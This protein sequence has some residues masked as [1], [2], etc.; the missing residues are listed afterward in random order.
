IKGFVSFENED[1]LKVNVK[2]VEK[3]EFKITDAT[4][5]F[6][7]KELEAGTY[8]VEV[9]LIGYKTKTQ[10]VEIGKNEIKRIEFKMEIS[11]SELDEVII[12]DQQTGLNNKTPYS[13]TPVKMDRIAY[14]SSPSGVMGVLRDVPGVYGAEFGQG[15][16]KPFIRGLGFSRVATI[17]QGNK[18]ENQQ[19]G[20]DHG[21]GVNDLG[22]KRIEII[23]GPA[24]VLYGSGALGGVI[25]IKDDQFYKDSENISG[26]VGTTYNSVSQG[27]RT[28][29]S[30]GKKFENGLYF[31]S[32]LA[33]ENHADYKSGYGEIIGNSRF[34]MKTF[35]FHLGLEKSDFNNRLSVTYN[36][37]NLGIISDDELQN[38]NAST[39]NDRDMQLP[40][41]EVEDLLLSYN[42]HTNHKN[43]ET[44]LH[45]SHHWNN[46]KEIENNYD[47]VD[48]GLRQHNT[49]YNANIGFSTKDLNHSLGIQGNRLQNKNHRNAKEILI[50]DAVFYENALYYMLDFDWNSYFIQAAIRYD[51][52]DVEADASDAFFVSNNFL[53]P[54][55]PEN[56]KLNSNFGGWTGSIGVSKDFNKIHKVKMNFSSGFRSPDLA[57]LYSFGQHPGTNRFEVGNANFNREQSLQLDMNYTLTTNRLRFDLSVF[58]SQIDNYIFF[59][60]TGETQAESDLQIW[61]Y[62]QVEAE[63]Y[64]SEAS[65]QYFALKNRQLKLNLGAALVRGNNLDFDEPL[66]FIPPDN[67]NFQANYSFGKQQQTSVFGQLRWVDEQDRPGFN[68]IATEGYQLVSLGIDHEFNFKSL[69]IE[70]ALK[71]DNLFN[72]NYVDHLS[73][74]RAFNIPSPGRNLNLNLRLH[75]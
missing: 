21:L 35:R 40:F 56:R 63:L 45:I 61:E 69:K 10:T 58:G 30:V 27:F 46:R 53:L 32:D 75:F 67:F 74:L 22:V 57:E 28:Y 23:K 59:S 54:G 9:S 72:E 71:I 43:F 64:G 60:D 15:I 16:V 7:F 18:L 25:L 34:N 5:S 13:F 47:E 14:K 42:Q 44:N 11:A 6:E 3:N 49:F 68:E 73:I 12:L 39:R 65:L 38:S 51:Y 1:N 26:S 31:G 19:W 4:N 29:A 66:T 36:Q 50:P 52:R 55:E 2:L 33:Y 17:Y 48:L 20:A 70:T 41:Q 8:H 37:Q 62:Q 24:S